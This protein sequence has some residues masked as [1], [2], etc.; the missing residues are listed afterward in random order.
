VRRLLGSELLRFRSRRL[1][2]V[3]LAGSLVAA[4]VGIV[5]AAWQST[6]PTDA[7]IAAARAQAQEDLNRCLEGD[8]DL[9]DE[10][11]GSPEEFCRENFGNPGPYL[12]SHLA[13]VGLPQI[14]QG[15][16]SITSIL[17][18]VIGASFV[19]ASWQTGTISTI[20]TW[21][22][23]R[24]RWF[25]ARIMVVAA[26][27]LMM[28]ALIVSFMSAGLALAAI[29]RGSTAGVGGAW[30]TD[31][32]TTSLRLSVAAAVAAVIGGAVAA[33][34][35]HTASA[36]GAVFIYTA[37]L[38]G[39]VRGFRPQWTPWLLGDNIVAFISWQAT[40]FQLASG[41]F[42]LSPGRAVFV[43]LGY[44]AVLLALGFIFVRIRDV[45]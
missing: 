43:I 1:V 12:P 29:L 13:L 27:V 22:P 36:L 25:A 23:R 14:L 26:G 32:V 7:V 6:P 10:F 5:I 8:F 42:V 2:V 4:A 37:V 16:S 19:A 17:G 20:F 9:P 18:L 38:E 35:R 30:W 15:I 24:L 45:Q 33:V 21:E 41:S 3:M 28:T 34:G 11:P 39:L 44:V 31:V 40:N